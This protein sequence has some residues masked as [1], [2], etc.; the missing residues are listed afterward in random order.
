MTIL[1]ELQAAGCLSKDLDH[2]EITLLAKKISELQNYRD[3]DFRLERIYE[4]EQL[5]TYLVSEGYM[6]AANY[7]SFAILKDAY[8]F[9]GFVTR[10]NGQQ[11][12]AGLLLTYD[13]LDE[14]FSAPRTQLSNTCLLYT[15]PSPRDATLSRMPSSA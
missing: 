5:A 9:E 11:F 4:F 1:E 7:K 14:N 2:A 10:E 12:T 3:V 13:Y 8:D 15:S 6:D